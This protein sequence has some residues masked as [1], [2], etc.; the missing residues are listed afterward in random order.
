[1]LPKSILRRLAEPG[2]SAAAQSESVCCYI[3]TVYKPKEKGTSPN[4]LQEAGF[5]IYRFILLPEAVLNKCRGERLDEAR[6]ALSQCRQKDLDRAR[7]AMDGA[8][9]GH[10][11]SPNPKRRRS[12]PPSRAGPSALAKSN[13]IGKIL[14]LTARDL[15]GPSFFVALPTAP[16]D[17][18]PELRSECE[19]VDSEDCEYTDDTAAAAAFSIPTPCS[20]DSE[21]IPPPSDSDFGCV[22]ACVGGLQVLNSGEVELRLRAA[23]AALV[24]ARTALGAI[25]RHSDLA[26]SPAGLSEEACRLATQAAR[27]AAALHAE[28]QLVIAAQMGASSPS[29]PS[30]NIYGSSLSESDRLMHWPQSGAFAAP[31]SEADSESWALSG[32]GPDPSSESVLAYGGPL[33]DSEG[34]QGL[35]AGRNLPLQPENGGPDSEAF[36]R[37]SLC[38][39]GLAW[40]HCT[41]CSWPSKS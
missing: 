39:C 29:Q 13:C 11:D 15:P 30:L 28:L 37:Q 38:A 20:E 10:S 21:S 4:P 32:F 27:A 17:S 26:S 40:Q 8:S 31:D 36:Q 6:A 19:D 16:E 23:M 2:S 14:G 25:P 1:M 12:A 33:A 24:A 22:T 34:S 41:R 3:S 9:D 5:K 18:G 7:A 35:Q